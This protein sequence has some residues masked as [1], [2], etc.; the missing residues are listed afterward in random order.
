MSVKVKIILFRWAGKLGPIRISGECLEC[1]FALAQVRGLLAAHADWPVELEVKPWL[2]H[3]WE[4]LCSGGWH[5]P[6]VL[7]NR[8]L[9][10][11]GE[12]PDYDALERSVRRALESSQAERPPL[13]RR[14]LKR[15]PPA[16][17]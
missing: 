5:A 15:L 10:S 4:A 3:W 14:L 16:P 8:E 1:D 11:Q 6:I 7:V 13:W 17:S 9:V 2:E 12:I